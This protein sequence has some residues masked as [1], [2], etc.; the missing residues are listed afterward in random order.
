[1]PLNE[2][3]FAKRMIISGCLRLLTVVERPGDIQTSRTAD[4]SSRTLGL[5]PCVC[6]TLLDAKVCTQQHAT[7]V[8][9]TV[10]VDCS[11]DLL[12]NLIERWVALSDVTSDI[13][14]STW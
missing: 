3:D 7:S 8:S 5:S 1:V 11:R 9:P 2:S 12:G 14:S 10:S 4:P 6:A 13:Q